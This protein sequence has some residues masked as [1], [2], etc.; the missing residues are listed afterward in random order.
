MVSF[1]AFMRNVRFDRIV[2]MQYKV[3]ILPSEFTDEAT[4]VLDDFATAYFKEDKEITSK[5]CR[6]CLH[7]SDF[8]ESITNFLE[9]FFNYNEEN[10]SYMLGFIP[11]SDFNARMMSSGKVREI[12][13]S[14]ECE[15]SYVKDL[16]EEESSDLPNLIKKVKNVVKEHRNGEKPLSEKTYDLIFGSIRHW[17]MSAS[18]RIYLLYER[19]WKAVS[20][21]K[22]VKCFINKESITQLVKYRNDITHGRSR[23]IDFHIAGTASAMIAVV[24]CCLLSRIGMTEEEIIDYV[25]KKFEEERKKKSYFNRK[26]RFTGFIL[27]KKY[28]GKNLYDIRIE[29]D[30]EQINQKLKDENVLINEKKVELFYAD[31]LNLN[32]FKNLEEENKKLKEEIELMKKKENFKNE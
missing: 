8:G 28:K 20:K 23:V 14:L 12:C 15:L 27:T 9:L 31:D 5:D 13:S 25:Y 24:Y 22:P 2:L 7:F 11:N 29:D 4:T 21:L 19:H 16:C 32:R 10:I 6:D 3:L 30:L 18:D 1:M 26:L 17:S